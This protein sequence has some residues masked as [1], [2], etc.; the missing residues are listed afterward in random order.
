MKRTILS[1]TFLSLFFFTSEAQ[2]FAIAQVIYGTNDNTTRIVLTYDTGEFEVI[3]L[4][5]YEP[6]INPD[7]WDT[8]VSESSKSKL[9]ILNRMKSE[10]YELTGAVSSPGGSELIFAKKK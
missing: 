10:G 3:P 2:N 9:D 6:L 1:L 5:R 4:K 8:V 7:K